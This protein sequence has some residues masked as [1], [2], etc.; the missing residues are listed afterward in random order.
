M[1]DIHSHILH[2]LDDGARSFDESLAMVRMAAETGTTDI[3]A[4]PHANSE[5]QFQPELIRDRVSEL[6]AAAGESI[7]IHS[8]CDFH[9][10]YDNVQDALANPKKY[11][12]DHKIYL[13]VEFS[14]FLIFHKTGDIFTKL[15]DVDIIP[16]I[17]HP[18]RNALLQQR[19]PEL[20]RWVDAGC[21]LQITGQS[22]LGTFGPRCKNFADLLMKKKLA[23][24]IASDAH[25]CE[26]RPPRLDLAYAHVVRK[27]GEQK[28]ERL[29]VE[30]PT[31]VIAGDR[32][33]PD[34]VDSE[35]ADFPRR[36]WYQFWGN[37]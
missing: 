11:T 17:T 18:E 12:I 22:L 1:I 15:M 30:N 2:Q 32:I 34:E 31:A 23:H 16:I 7:R 9:L 26:R 5:F 3:V 8:G 24:L 28:A 14:D 21:L 33:Y 19:L 27:F 35:E 4:T 25:D 13:L 29:F 10:Q 37:L 20:S 36:K 6:Q